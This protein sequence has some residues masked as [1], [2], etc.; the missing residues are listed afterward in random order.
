MH[1]IKANKSKAGFTGF[2]NEAGVGILAGGRSSEVGLAGS[3]AGEAA[4]D[5]GRGR[6]DDHQKGQS[7]QQRLH[8]CK[9]RRHQIKNPCFQSISFSL[10]GRW[11]FERLMSVLSLISHR[12]QKIGRRDVKINLRSCF[13]FLVNRENFQ[14]S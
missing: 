13:R 14:K 2:S 12:G 9:E 5:R 4:A 11:A 8:S 10:L 1:L 7:G 3:V 6:S